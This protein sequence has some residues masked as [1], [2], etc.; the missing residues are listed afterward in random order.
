[1]FQ[2][3]RRRGFTLIELLVVIAI[4]GILTALLM[5]ACII[6]T[7][8]SWQMVVNSIRISEMSSDP[9]GLLRWPIKICIP[10]GFALL[11]LQGIATT[12]HGPR[13]RNLLQRLLV[14]LF[15]LL[16]HAVP[17]HRCFHQLPVVVTH[18]AA[19]RWISQQFD[20]RTCQ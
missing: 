15:Q 20:Q 11:G 2:P 5:P 19:F 1:M 14:D 10:I 9:G 13:R 16:R 8:L 12:M 3:T 4:I 18:R 6:I 7:W 17:T